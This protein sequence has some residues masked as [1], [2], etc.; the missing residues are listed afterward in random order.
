VPRDPALAA[1]WTEQAAEAGNRQA[2]FEIGVAY[3]NGEGVA[4]DLS[5]AADWSRR[6]AEAGHP[7]AK[8]NL[9]RFQMQ[10]VGVPRDPVEAMKW[11]SAAIEDGE[12]T[13]IAAL[14]E[15]FA[16]WSDPP[17]VPKARKLLKQAAALGD[18]RATVMLARLNVRA[19][20]G[21]SAA[22]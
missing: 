12:M 14:G 4:R 8:V 19:E 11:L 20:G 13:A 3:A 1:R 10:G 16:F 15:L 22:H 6:A 2:Q 5:R 7:T 17:D 18:Q 9:G 21:S